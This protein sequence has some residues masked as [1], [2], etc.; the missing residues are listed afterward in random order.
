MLISINQL[1]KEFLMANI[2]EV[3]NICVKDGFRIVNIQNLERKDEMLLS[4]K[5]RNDYN[6]SYISKR[7]NCAALSKNYSLKD[8]H[9]YYYT[10]TSTGEE[11]TIE[12]N[13]FIGSFLNA[14]NTHSDVVLNP[15]NIWIMISL[16]FSKYVDKN[17]ETLRS[18][19]VNHD[20][21]K[22]LVVKEYASSVE[23]SLEMEKQW[24]YFYEQIHE[25]V[26]SNTKEGVVD[27]LKCDFST[28]GTVEKIISTS[29]I[30]NS[31]KKYF[32]YGRAICCCGI[33]NVYFQGI[34]EDW[35]KLINKTENLAQYDVDGQMKKYIDHI[36][37]I[38]NQFVNTWDGSVDVEFWNRIMT[39]EE[40]RIGS[41]GDVQTNIQGWI[42]HFFGEYEKMDLD[43]VPDYSIAVPVELVNYLTGTTKNLEIVANW[44]SVS[45][46]NFYTY[47]S[48]LGLAIV[49]KV[50]ER[51]MFY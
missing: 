18:K 16:Y 27:A 23:Q 1:L 15:D 42:L 46:V 29:V 9:I 6:K 50:E 40:K 36:L 47:K 14:Y 28:T 3:S 51:S 41:G 38:L 45:K 4:K 19:F 44:L 8:D 22:K 17:A 2:E 35:T 33:N 11:Q 30:M 20:G 31:F 34:R 21:Q 10:D 7:S 43:D 48:D 12:T 26:K 24:D 25:Q 32:S 13:N 49:E 37:I 5:K 39:T